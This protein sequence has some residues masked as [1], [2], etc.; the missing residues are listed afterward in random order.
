MQFLS[1]T[2]QQDDILIKHYLAIWD[3]YGIPPEHFAP[4]AEMNVRKFIAEGRLHRELASFIAMA[5]DT[6]VGLVSCQAHLS[7]YPDVLKLEVRKYGYIWSVFVEPTYRR[8]GASK[9]LVSLA[10]KHLKAIGCTV[11]VLHSSDAGE[12]VYASLGFK[13]AKE[14]RLT[15]S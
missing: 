3:S 4:D 2:S 5:N 8:Q 14:M 6:V 10:V 12:S 13:L 11:V 15:I 1:A 7:P 9:Q